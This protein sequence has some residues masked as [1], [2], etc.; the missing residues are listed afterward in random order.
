[1]GTAQVLERFYKFKSSSIGDSQF[2]EHPATSK[3]DDT[4]D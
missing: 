4:V 1:M 3:T 2:S